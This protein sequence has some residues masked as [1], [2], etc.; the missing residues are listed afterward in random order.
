MNFVVSW[1]GPSEDEPDRGSEVSVEDVD[2]LGAVLDR[3]AAQAARDGLAYAVQIHQPGCHGAVLF[4]IGHAHRS[5]LDGLDRG[6]PHGTGDRFAVDTG[7]PAITEDLA[8]DVYGDWSE[9]PPERTRI[10]PTLAY[11]AAEEYIR[12]RKR[13][14]C[15]S[16]M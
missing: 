15:V 1:D 10:T 2:D 7:T 5:F 16:W 3:V 9:M 6:Q 8:F 11:R 12:T 4:G 13:P 14:T